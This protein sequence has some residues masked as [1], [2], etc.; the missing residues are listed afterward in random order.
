MYASYRKSGS[1]Q[2]GSQNFQTCWVGFDRVYCS[3]IC[4]LYVI[5][6]RTGSKK[7][8]VP[9]GHGPLSFAVILSYLLPNN[10]LFQSSSSKMCKS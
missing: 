6:N 7:K 10:D 5:F 1:G 8:E 4:N 9:V 2:V 3:K